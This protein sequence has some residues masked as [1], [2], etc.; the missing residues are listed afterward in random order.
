MQALVTTHSGGRDNAG[1]QS[2]NSPGGVTVVGRGP[3]VSA[4]PPAV[5]TSRVPPVPVWA[6]RTVAVRPSFR[7]MTTPV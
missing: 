4:A 1:I 6:N 7:V 3:E 2:L 5:L